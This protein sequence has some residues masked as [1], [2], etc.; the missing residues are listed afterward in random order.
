MTWTVTPDTDGT[1]LIRFDGVDVGTFSMLDTSPVTG[2][3]LYPAQRAR[4]I[5]SLCNDFDAIV[6]GD[7]QV[8]VR[9][10]IIAAGWA[11]R[12]DYDAEVAVCRGLVAM[13]PGHVRLEAARQYEAHGW[14]KY[15]T[16][17]QMSVWQDE[18]LDLL[19]AHERTVA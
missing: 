13:F 6:A 18:L 14:P 8:R 19:A 10:E 16:P 17:A 12:D 7:E 9:S 4:Q 5:A 2:V 11:S 15:L 1:W 3:P